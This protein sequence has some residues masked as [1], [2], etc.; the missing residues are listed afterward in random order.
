MR[1]SLSS[2][3]PDAA[4]R[5][6]AA[7]DDEQ[8]PAVDAIDDRPGEWRGEERRQGERD[9]DERHEQGGVGG[10]VDVAGEGDEHEPVAEE[11]HHLGAEHPA[12][13]AVGAQQFEH[14]RP[15]NVAGATG[16]ANDAS[17][18]PAGTSRSEPH[19]RP[20]VQRQTCDV[21]MSYVLTQRSGDAARAGPRPP[22][23]LRS[24]LPLPGV[25]AGADVVGCAPS[26]DRGRRRP[27]RRQAERDRSMVEQGRRIGGVP[28]AALAGAMIAL[29]EHLRGSQARRRRRSW[30][31]T[32]SEPHDVDR[33]GMDFD[34]DEVG[35]D[36]D[37][38]APPQPRLPARGRRTPTPPPPVSGRYLRPTGIS[39]PTCDYGYCYHILLVTT[40]R[41]S[42]T[43]TAS[44][45]PRWGS[46]KKCSGVPTSTI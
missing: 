39:A 5:L 7:D 25:R 37:V 34:H 30:S 29:R 17:R 31:S 21:L 27:G 19:P 9:E 23:R 15:R 14:D 11:R 36:V 41:G 8:A 35:G 33:E 10:V 2:S 42:A 16:A 28:V 18:P 22:D 43:G 38:F 45:G 4:D 20:D 13:V 46:V 44:C 26:E 40:T 3:R 12:Q 24:G 32:P 1:S 6:Q